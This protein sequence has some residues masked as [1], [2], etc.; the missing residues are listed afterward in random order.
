MRTKLI[1]LSA[2][3]LS[4]CNYVSV[5]LLTPYKMDIR[6]GNLVTPEMRGKLKLGMTKQQVNYVLGTP[7]VNDVFHPDRWDY[8]YRLAHQGKEV[9]KQRMTLYFE[10]DKLA[11]IDDSGMPPYTPPPAEPVP[12][13]VEAVAPAAEAPVAAAAPEAVPAPAAK[14]AMSD[15]A[16]E[17]LKSLQAWAE[18]W[19]SQKIDAYLAA[20]APDFKPKGMSHAAWAEQRRS[21]IGKAKG[22]ELGLGN[23]SIH[24]HD[25]SH[26]T[27]KFVQ[28]YRSAAYRDD[29]LKTLVLEKQDGKWLIT[30]EETEKQKF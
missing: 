11:R 26:A 20:Y 17:V 18:A 21:R 27:V 13:P 3:L 25:E 19:S 8:D 16:A 4:A 15:P 5:P 24:I 28:N 22:I 7:L 29:L 12:A 6:Q 2:V 10:D 9:E 1:L 23:V 14:P 30:S